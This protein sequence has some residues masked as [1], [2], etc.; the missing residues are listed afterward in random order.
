M[1]RWLNEVDAGMD[2]VVN[3]F[4]M[5]DLVLVLQI[6]AGSRLDVL[7]NWPPTENAFQNER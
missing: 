3:D 7:K 2:A 5:V 6:L 1:T 4:L